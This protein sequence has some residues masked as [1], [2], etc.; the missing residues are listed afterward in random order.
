MVEI[1]SPSPWGG[2]C[3]CD[4]K[5][6]EKY[7]DRPSTLFLIRKKKKNWGEKKENAGQNQILAISFWIKQKLNNIDVL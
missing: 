5:E 3:L 2:L 7:S 4:H 6:T 1:I